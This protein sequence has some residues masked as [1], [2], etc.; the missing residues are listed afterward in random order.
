MHLS[1]SV[2]INSNEDVEIIYVSFVCYKV[3]YKSDVMFYIGIDQLITISCD[4]DV[5]FDSLSCKESY[6]VSVYWKSSIESLPNCLLDEALAITPKCPPSS[7]ILN[8]IV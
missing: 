6:N 7:E 3:D 1:V 4:S 8:F 2:N 5:K